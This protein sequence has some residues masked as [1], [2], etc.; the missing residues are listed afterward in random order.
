MLIII[1]LESIDITTTYSFSVSVSRAGTPAYSS[2][3]T[4]TPQPPPITTWR[5][6]WPYSWAWSGYIKWVVIM[7]TGRGLP[8]IAVPVSVLVV[9]F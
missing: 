8:A 2:V 6:A 9:V 1:I 7:A 4:F 5:Q 3:C